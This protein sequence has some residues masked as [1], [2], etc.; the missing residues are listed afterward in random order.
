MTIAVRPSLPVDGIDLIL[1]NHLGHDSV[2]PFQSPPPPV[3]RPK[4][5]EL[6]IES[7]SVL[8]SSQR[9]SLPV[10]LLVLWLVHR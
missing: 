3:V 5:L 8:K 10:Q 1:G 9:C 4:G 6:S 7:D 2:F